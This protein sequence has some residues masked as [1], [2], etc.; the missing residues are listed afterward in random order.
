[1]EAGSFYCYFKPSLANGGL[2]LDEIEEANENYYQ[3]SS[4]KVRDRFTPKAEVIGSDEFRKEL[5]K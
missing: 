3:A 2:G 5:E 4:G 1:M